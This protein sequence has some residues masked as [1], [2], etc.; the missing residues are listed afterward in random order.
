MSIPSLNLDLPALAKW[1]AGRVPNALFWTVSGSHLYG[2][3]S[4]DSDIDLRGCFAAPLR[5]LVGLK[6]PHETVEPKGELAGIEVEA[7]SHEVGKY[8]LLL[9]KHNGYVLEQILSPLVVTGVDFLTELRPLAR[10]C[11]TRYCYH[12]YR[13]F[14]QTQRK[15]M[16]KEEVVRAKTLLYAYRVVLT[17]VHLLETGE[18]EPNLPALNDRFRLPYVPEL[19]A[20]KSAAETGTLLELDIAFHRA[21]LDRW[22]QRLD[23]AFESS[24]LP[25]DAPKEELHQFLVDLRLGV[26]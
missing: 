25:A 10:R 15:L 20:R 11:I 1:A 18:L 21:E 17:G 23:A 22:Q 5:E 13:G 24:W 4:I 9:C 2:F 14:L 8:L 26:S 19:I 16:D 12:H 6:T 7:V 3:S